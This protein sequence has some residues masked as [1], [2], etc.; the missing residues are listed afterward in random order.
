MCSRS[1]TSL[2]PISSRTFF[3]FS[4]NT[5]DL[6]HIGNFVFWARLRNTSL[7]I[8]FSNVS[9][10]LLDLNSKE[11]TQ[12][13]FLTFLSIL[14]LTTPNPKPFEVTWYSLTFSSAVLFST[15]KHRFVININDSPFYILKKISA[16]YLIL[17]QFT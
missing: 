17:A 7:N 9:S 13:F 11:I 2:A 6:K 4:V 5:L 15:I 1:T 3:V 8:S 14:A 16:F 12:I 10:L